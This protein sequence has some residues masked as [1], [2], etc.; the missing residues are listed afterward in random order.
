[1]ARIALRSLSGS[2]AELLRKL[3]GG[4][5]EALRRLSMPEAPLRAALRA[6]STR[7]AYLMKTTARKSEEGRW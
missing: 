2:P 1:M 4:S 5:Q 7:D 3:S 6:A